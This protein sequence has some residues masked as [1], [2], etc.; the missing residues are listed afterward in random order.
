MGGTGVLLYS[1]GWRFSFE[2]KT[3]QKIGAIYVKTNVGNATITVNGKP[4]KDTSGILQSGTLISNLLPKTYQVEIAKERYRTYHKTLTV[5]P[6]QVAEILN[7]QLIPNKLEPTFIAPTK[8]TRF[9]DT[10]Q[11][12]GKMILQ[13]ATTGTYY[14]YDKTNISATLNLNLAIARAQRGPKIKKIM[15]VPFKPA[16]FVIE[17]S[18]G[19]KLFDSEKNTVETLEKGLIVTWSM[20]D[21]TIVGV[22]MT[23]TNAKSRAQK[24]FTL[25]LIFKSK[26]MLDEL[27]AR[28]ATTTR[29]VALATD[30]DGP[31]AFSDADHILFLFDPKTKMI[32]RVANNV[33]SFMFSPDGKKLAFVETNGTLRVLFIEDFDG[34]IRKKSGDT[35]TV[36][37]PQEHPV[38]TVRWY[39]DSYHLVIGLPDQIAITELDDRKPL[40][41][42]PLL[43][44]PVEYRYVTGNNSVYFIDQKGI[45]A[46][47]IEQ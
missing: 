29:I 10:T 11:S 14:L 24:A 45:N 37:L 42:F 34:D 27:N 8:G 2:T 6:S 1:Y 9:I 26:T 35:I 12:A 36:A 43:N 30:D 44:G 39:A 13:D 28:M 46:I 15:F 22:E 3:F 41:T 31:I 20:Q 7:V 25:N 21:S 40:N 18:T 5:R 23:G 19:L 32:K 47:R 38:Q 16:Q 33:T 4:Y 17:D